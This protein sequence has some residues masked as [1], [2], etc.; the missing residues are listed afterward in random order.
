MGEGF[1]SAPIYC[2]LTAVKEGRVYTPDVNPIERQSH[3]NGEGIRILA[4]IFHPEA[5][6]E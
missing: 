5:F 6:E 3:R 2:D 4:E 1:A